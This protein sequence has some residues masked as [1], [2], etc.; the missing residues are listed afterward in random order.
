MPFLRLLAQRSTT[1]AAHRTPKPNSEVELEVLLPDA[2]YHGLQIQRQY[3]GIYFDTR[4]K[5]RRIWVKESE[6]SATVSA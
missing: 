5:G 3:N 6:H 4:I 2:Q 1:A